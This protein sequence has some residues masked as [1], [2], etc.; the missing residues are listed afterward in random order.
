KEIFTSPEHPQ[1]RHLLETRL[2]LSAP[3]EAL[4]QQKRVRAFPC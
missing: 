3:L 1:T 4:R 2:R